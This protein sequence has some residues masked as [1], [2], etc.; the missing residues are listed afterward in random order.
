MKRLAL[1]LAVLAA[2]CTAELGRFTVMSTKN[3]DLSAPHQVVQRGVEGD[4][5]RFWLLFIPFGGAPTI[6]GAV[7]EALEESEGDYLTSV[8][9]SEGGFWVVLFGYGWVEAK[10]DVT[11]VFP[12]KVEYRREAVI[13]PLSA[14]EAGLVR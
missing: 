8:T 7:D 5:G 14:N 11:K 10:G 13:P 1:L 6:T 9:V 12:E 2:G 3:V 4:E